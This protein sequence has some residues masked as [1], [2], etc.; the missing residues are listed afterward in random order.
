I[1]GKVASDLVTIVPGQRIDQ[2][3]ETL[4]KAGF[5]TDE[6]NNALDPAVW[7]DHPALTDKPAEASLEGY[8]YP[9]SFQKTGE[10][11]AKDIVKLALD[12][13]ESKF[14]PELRQA[15]SKQGM[16]LHQAVTLASVIER[17]VHV[18]EDRAQVAQVF[19]KRL[20]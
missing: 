13:M 2:I 10:T 6:V 3:N 20:K 16:T 18:P 9:E 11:T 5:S 1:E 4:V 7:V 14:T 12:E 19:L 15:V 17:E 8:I